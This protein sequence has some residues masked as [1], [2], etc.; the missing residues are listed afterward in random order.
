[1]FQMFC[2][3]LVNI[4]VFCV[5]LTRKYLNKN[6]KRFIRFPKN[7]FYNKYLYECCVVGVS[8][9]IVLLQAHCIHRGKHQAASREHLN[10]N[11]IKI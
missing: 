10:F 6:N 9:L 11:T 7:A 1:M 2:G 5:T 8:I 3:C 4:D